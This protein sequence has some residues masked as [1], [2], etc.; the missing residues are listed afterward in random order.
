MSR[1]RNN[2]DKNIDQP[3][4][5]EIKLQ[6][7]LDE[8]WSG[9]LEGMAINYADEHT[10]L[11]GKMADQAALRGLLCKVWDLNQTI[12]SLNQVATPGSS[13]PLKWVNIS[14]NNKNGVE[15]L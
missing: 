5:Y 9:W 13:T 4:V 15:K 1:A 6:G 2:E 7:H 12:I 8:S 10:I 11:T 14:G 3:V